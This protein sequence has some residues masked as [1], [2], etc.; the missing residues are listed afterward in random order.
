MCGC[1]S[2]VC[3]D[4]GK[5][6]LFPGQ[7]GLDK[8]LL[9]FLPGQN[10]VDALHNQASGFAVGLAGLRK[11]DLGEAAQRIESLDSAETKFVAPQLRARWLH[12]QVQ[13]AAVGKFV[14]LRGR[15]C[16]ID[17]DCGQHGGE[18][19]FGSLG[20]PQRYPQVTEMSW[21]HLDSTGTGS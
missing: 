9:S 16:R 13:A 3:C 10:R 15:L 5:R 19:S 7:I 6:P 20:Y 2:P 18:A 11:R 21:S 17:L 14:R 8:R 1:G 4:S 12:K